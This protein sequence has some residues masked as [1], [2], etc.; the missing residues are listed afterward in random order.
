MQQKRWLIPPILLCA[1]TIFLLCAIGWAVF[2]GTAITNN[3]ETTSLRALLG[4]DNHAVRILM[5]LSVISFVGG[6]L[7]VPIVALYNIKTRGRQ[8]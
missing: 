5:L 3:P 6:F 7:S 4:L 1:G 2:S 8:R